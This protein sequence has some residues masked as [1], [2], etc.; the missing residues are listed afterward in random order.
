M[1]SSEPILETPA[2]GT[3]PLLVRPSP[4][5]WRAGERDWLIATAGIGAPLELV[6]TRSRH[7]AAWAAGL[8]HYAVFDATFAAGRLVG[9]VMP[10]QGRSVS[11]APKG[12]GERDRL[13]PSIGMVHAVESVRGHLDAFW[14]VAGEML[15]RPACPPGIAPSLGLSL[16]GAAVGAAALR[17]LLPDWEWT[18]VGGAPTIRDWARDRTLHRPDHEGLDGGAWN[19][20]TAEWQKH[21]WLE[22][23]KDD[24]HLIV[25]LAAD[26]VGL[27]PVNIERSRS[28][29][30]RPSFRSAVP[31]REAGRPQNAR[32][33]ERL[34]PLILELV[35]RSMGPGLR[36]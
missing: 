32:V 18:V 6:P 1:V 22:A 11:P 7:I 12:L 25:D 15:G 14:A 21:H 8:E 16:I 23:R 30:Y 24:C 9:F 5:R 2:D 13:D 4:R 31:M 35:S 29:R 34:S 19:E 36:A 10:R 27:G 26:A 28:A 33:V 3:R 17:E 20:A